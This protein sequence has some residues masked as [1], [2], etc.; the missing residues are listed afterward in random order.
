M[1]QAKQRKA[2][3]EQLKKAKGKAYSILAIRHCEDGS[4]EFAYFEANREKSNFPKHDL[5]AY[6]CTND[7]VHTPPVSAI[8]YYLWQTNSF[9]M[10]S[11]VD[12]VEGFEINFYEYDAEISAKKGQ[13]CFSCRAIVAGDKESILERANQLKEELA[14]TGEYSIQENFKV[15]A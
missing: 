6:I 15:T 13:K 5:L 10:L 9:Q 12:S 1:G 7:W 2:E 4:K 11:D 14:Q 3:I 8:A